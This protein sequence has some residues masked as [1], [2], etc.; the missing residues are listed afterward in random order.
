MLRHPCDL[1]ALFGD[2]LLAHDG[3]TRSDTDL[4]VNARTS[5]I[6][7]RA[8]PKDLSILD[9]SDDRRRAELIGER[10]KSWKSMTNA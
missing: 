6:Y 3:T 9:G 7:L 2:P 4:E 8:D 5:G 10:L 1:P